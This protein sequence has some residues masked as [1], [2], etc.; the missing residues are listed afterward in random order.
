MRKT[1]A[2]T[3]GTGKPG[4]GKQELIKI[5]KAMREIVRSGQADNI[6]DAIKEFVYRPQGHSEL[7]SI[8]EWN[9]AGKRVIKGSKALLLW[10][11]PITRR[12]RQ[13]GATPGSDAEDSEY[14]FWNVCYLFS[15]LQV[16]EGS[17]KS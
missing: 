10:S 9:K 11:A 8:H 15:N 3:S 12:S 13:P 16:E 6:N 17:V 5:S 1:F 14:R 2:T 4:P 7:K